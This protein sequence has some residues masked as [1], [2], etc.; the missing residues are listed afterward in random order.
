M[1]LP[2][3]RVWA[4][5]EELPIVELSHG[6]PDTKLFY[7]KQ[8]SKAPHRVNCAVLMFTDRKWAQRGEVGRLGVG[9]T[10]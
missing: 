6:K 5:C 3:C 8:D 2:I 9:P 7:A 4:P 10:V 1:V